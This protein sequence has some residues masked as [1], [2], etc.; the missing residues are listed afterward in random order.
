VRVQPSVTGTAV[1]RQLTLLRE[2]HAAIAF[3]GLTRVEALRLAGGI[4]PN[5]VDGYACDTAWMAAVAR[6][7]DLVRV[8]G[9]LYRKRHHR[10]SEHVRWARW[11]FEK[12][13]RAWATHCAAMLE[14]ALRVPSE[15]GER[16][17]LWEAA[18]GRL[19]SPRLAGNLL[20]VAGFGAEE[21]AALLDRLIDAAGARG[22]DLP[23][24]LA[25]DPE[26]VRSWGEAALAPR[27]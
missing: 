5:E 13:L 15:A 14:Q 17:G 6:W 18:V 1:A 9:A 7:G 12:R 26:A 19:V 10:A 21:R 4:P 20:P 27:Y 25:A 2:H 3:R 24:R 8:P 22:I 16:R 11:P 23:G